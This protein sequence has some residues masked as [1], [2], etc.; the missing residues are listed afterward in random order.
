MVLS[1]CASAEVGQALCDRPCRRSF[2]KKRWTPKIILYR[3]LYPRG[4]RV[5]GDMGCERI[6]R[7]VQR[8][9]VLFLLSQRRTRA[10]CRDVHHHQP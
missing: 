4:V 7:E 8:I 1:G 2:S 6:H 5:V 9:M 10:R 3:Y